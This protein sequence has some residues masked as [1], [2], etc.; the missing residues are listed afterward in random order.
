MSTCLMRLIFSTA[1]TIFVL[2]FVPRAAVVQVGNDNR[3]LMMNNCG[4]VPFSLFGDELSTGVVK[5]I[6]V[7][8][9]CAQDSDLYSVAEL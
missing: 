7:P 6:I 8:S 5:L 9:W 2:Y 4:T 1:I 3:N